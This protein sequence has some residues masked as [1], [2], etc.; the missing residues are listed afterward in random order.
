MILNFDMMRI[1]G[2]CVACVLLFRTSLPAADSTPSLTSNTPSSSSNLD[3]PSLAEV[4]AEGRQ[5]SDLKNQVQPKV[6]TVN[7]EP[8][9]IQFRDEIAPL[10]NDACVS[11][12]GD[13]V[14]EN[15]FRVDTLDPNLIHGDD[16][17]WWVGIINVISNGEM[18]PEGEVELADESR[19]KIV[20]WLSAEIQRASL[21]R[22]SEGNHSAFRRMTR[23]EYNYALQDLLGLPYDFAQDLP[24]ET[25]SEDG[26]TNSS[27]VL[28]M[29]SV[30]FEAYRDLSRKAL[31]KAIVQGDRPEPWYWGISMQDAYD[32]LL[33]NYEKTIQRVTERNKEY[34]D[35][36]K[37]ALEIQAKAMEPVRGRP[38]YKN[39]LT[40]QSYRTQWR[41][42]GALYAMEPT[43][44]RREIPS[45]SDHVAIL[46]ARQKLI[47]EL[48][49]RIQD[50]GV[51]RVRVR[52]CRT[53]VD[54]DR[55]PAME[56]SF[57][58]QASNNSSAEEVVGHGEHL[59]TASPD[60]PGFYEWEIPLTEVARNPL[61]NIAK[62]GETPNPSE[63][64]KLH[65]CSTSPSDI[66][67][68]YVEVISPAYDQWPPVSHR[69]VLGQGS[70]GEDENAS[71][72]EVLAHFMPKAWR[73]PI[74]DSEIDQKMRMFDRV[75][76]MCDHFEEAII[77]VLATVLSSP[78]FLYLP[79][80]SV[81]LN[82]VTTTDVVAESLNLFQLATRLSV[83]LW[84]SSPDEE[85]MSK[86]A[87]GTLANTEV[88]IAHANR[89]LADPKAER[90]SEQFVRGWL[91]L[92][93]L[94]YLQ[95]DKKAYPGFDDELKSSM[96]REPIAF[97]NEVLQQNGSVVDFLHCDYAIVNE[98]LAKH[99]GIANVYGRGFRRVAFAS[100]D[101]RG[102]VLTQ[103]GLL[104]MNS[105]GKDS[106]PLKRG[107]WLLESV[108][109]DPPPPAPPAVPEIDLADPKIAKMT[110]KER[111]ENHR[112]SPACNSCHS[113]I[114]PW[115]IAFENYD[116]VGRFRNDINGKPVDATSR[117]FNQQELAGV[118]GL[119]RFLLA[120]R[121]DQ[122]VRALTH[123]L[124][125]FGLG[126]PLTFSDRAE[127]EHIAAQARR[128]GDGLSDLIRLIITSDLFQDGRSSEATN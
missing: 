99:Y 12:H 7:A 60:S 23:Y 110:L 128:Q 4:K 53:S 105:D 124:I 10:L 8:N 1:A 20:D 19:G 65:N 63:Y 25:A 24:P 61:R 89:L 104:A 57:G 97:F 84:C 38:F 35:Q 47:V 95:V 91:G 126:R 74:S 51:L 103:A 107:I 66:Q 73:R 48:G 59:I 33:V 21:I 14:Q 18:P 119:K 39:L 41:Y 52:A 13:E 6:S 123:K 54:D 26:F 5:R 90:F 36:L 79:R 77:E 64:L 70:I 121:Q 88:L 43:R 106:H 92:E 49:D 62:M 127:V 125:T 55:V 102:G 40:E 117:L 112:N 11:C 113:K 101:S 58:H 45:E 87:D 31:E 15:G 27:E 46:P 69:L 16:V 83:F 81:A 29:S 9:L 32:R 120:N 109:N 94:D 80:R 2:L 85:L 71:A 78:N 72:R 100:E 28:H 44:T 118:D 17:D 22:R 111:I 50:S 82:D 116:A 67:I 37:R 68:D 30:Q 34:P 86:A 56:L 122:F 96:Q 115:G 114:D 93:L 3:V 98:R 76:P 42:V 75:R 108:L